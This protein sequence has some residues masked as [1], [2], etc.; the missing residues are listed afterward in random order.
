MYDQQAGALWDQ[1]MKQYL[2]A[3]GIAVLQANP[4]SEDSWDAFEA[5]WDGKTQGSGGV[6]KPFLGLLFEEMSAGKFGSVDMSKVVIRG[7]SSGAQMVSWLF[8]VTGSNSSTFTSLP[9]FAGGVFL[10]GGSYACYNDP[11]VSPVTQP[12]G[13]CSGCTEGGPSHCA[14]DPKCS[15]CDPTVKTYCQQ[16][17]PRNYTEQFYADHPEKYVDHPPVFLGQLATGDSHA[18]ACACKNYYESMQ[19][20]APNVLSVLSLVTTED[21]S[22]FCVGNPANPNATGSPFSS[23]CSK[24]DWGQNCGVMGGPDCCITHTFGFADMVVPAVN[25]VLAATSDTV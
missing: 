18:D 9:K 20:N 21:A 5:A 17:C 24:P 19:T 13:S 16:C 7:W 11:Q 1:R 2:V 22:C 6:D 10:S 3:N 15:S 12:V 25:F 23:E 14:D 8:Q 4:V